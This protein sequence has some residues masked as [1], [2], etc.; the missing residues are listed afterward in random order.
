MPSLKPH[1]QP[2]GYRPAVYQYLGCQIFAQAARASGNEELAKKNEDAIYADCKGNITMVHATRGRSLEALRSRDEW[3]R[4]AANPG[5]IEH[6]FGV[7]YDDVD[8]LAIMKQLGLRHVVVPAGGGCVRAWNVGAHQAKGEVIVQVSD[9]FIPC[10]HWDELILERL[11]DTTKPKV[12]AVSDG[13]RSDGLLCIA[14]VTKARIAQQAGGLLFWR[15]YKSMYS[16][17][18]FS[19]RAYAD[20]VVIEA[21]DL[22]FEH[23]HPLAAGIPVEKWHKTTRE[24]NSEENYKTGR[25]I[26]ERRNQE[27]I[28]LMVERAA[29]SQK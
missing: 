3:Y 19:I 10:Y 20:S 7:D 5:G 25:E 1:E 27:Q 12:L 8:C 23:H 16:D 21:K 9:D 28:K 4:R 24:S 18:E 29:K 2:F 22:V 13:L 6:I 11:G 26:F 17:N 15:E 14:I